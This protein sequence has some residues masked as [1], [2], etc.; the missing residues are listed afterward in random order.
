MKKSILFIALFL[1]TAITFAQSAN[2]YMELARDVIKT[3]KKA[4]IAEAMQ[5]TDTESVPFWKL[6]NEYNNELA[7][8]NTKMINV[9]KD[10]A[11]NYGKMTD[12]KAKQIWAENMKIK[13]EAAKLE[14]KYF[15]KFLKVIPPT[16]TVR[17]FQAENKIKA[18]INAKL[19]L[20]IPLFE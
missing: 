8:V 12:D 19:A 15:K 17:Y 11:N 20:E 3:E 10:Y 16:K 9:I 2:D 7:D 5:L 18:L 14:K 6:Y 4:A 13:V 1:T